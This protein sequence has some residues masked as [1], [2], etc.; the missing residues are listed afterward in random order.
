MSEPARLTATQFAETFYKVPA[1]VTHGVRCGKPNC[2]CATSEYRHP[3]TCLF[4]RDGYGKL[5]RRYVRKAEVNEVRE[6]IELRQA[7]AREQRRERDLS[8][9]HVRTLMRWLRELRPEVYG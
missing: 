4:W 1:L 7:I 6:I 9:L 2:K 3:S 5:R 8:R